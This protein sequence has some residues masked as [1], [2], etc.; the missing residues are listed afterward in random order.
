ML[1]EIN[2]NC[3][4]PQ[5]SDKMEHWRKERLVFNILLFRLFRRTEGQRKDQHRCVLPSYKRRKGKQK[6]FYLPWWIAYFF[7]FFWTRNCWKCSSSHIEVR[8]EWSN[9]AGCSPL[10]WIKDNCVNSKRRIWHNNTEQVEIIKQ[11]PAHRNESK[12]YWREAFIIGQ[13]NLENISLFLLWSTNFL[14]NN[15]R[16]LRWV[17]RKVYNSCL[18][19]SLEF[20]FHSLPLP[21]KWQQLFNC[22][23]Q[24][25]SCHQSSYLQIKILWGKPF[26][27]WQKL[28]GFQFHQE[29]VQL[30]VKHEYIKLSRLHHRFRWGA[31]I[32]T[33]RQN[34]KWKTFDKKN[35]LPFR[36]KDL[37]SSWAS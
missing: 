35:S 3:E 37:S 7:F 34:N 27:H 10:Y 20:Y 25:W 15:S 1:Q 14:N 28:N 29:M 9:F 22:L 18:C 33:F 6:V 24:Q 4:P 32:P 21:V 36:L 16:T 13:K 11:L 31:S 2:R 8:H 26:H 17:W 30:W 12:F 19:H 5:Q 23:R